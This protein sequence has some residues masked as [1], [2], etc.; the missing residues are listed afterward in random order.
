MDT[1]IPVNVT[2][3]LWRQTGCWKTLQQVHRPNLF[4]N[5]AIIFC[6]PLV[7]PSCQ[8]S[9]HPTPFFLITPLSHR[10]IGLRGKKKRLN[11]S[12]HFI[13]PWVIVPV[14]SSVAHASTGLYTSTSGF[15]RCPVAVSHVNRSASDRLSYPRSPRAI[16]IRCSP[17]VLLF[18]P[19]S[20]VP[21]GDNWRW[22][23]S[24][25]RIKDKSPLRK[26]RPSQ[27]QAD[28]NSPWRL[29]RWMPYI[30][31]ATSQKTCHYGCRGS[32]A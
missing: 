16:R 6:F 30:V 18:R 20:T 32:M 15:R 23:I 28:H 27:L 11:H 21:N 19:P 3:I 25:K 8:L 24:R 26:A 1:L 4:P 22:E 9:D 2:I 13:V 29:Y 12:Q 14:A 5:T 7:L 17:I 10:L 31:S